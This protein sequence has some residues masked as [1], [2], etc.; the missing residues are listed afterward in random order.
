MRIGSHMPLRLK[1]LRWEVVSALETGWEGTEKIWCWAWPQA[2]GRARMG[3]QRSRNNS[4]ESCRAIFLLRFWPK[5]EFGGLDL[6]L[7]GLLE[8][9]DAHTGKN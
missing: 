7:V 5:S 1:A 6:D 9:Q 2:P 3:T 4:R 8:E